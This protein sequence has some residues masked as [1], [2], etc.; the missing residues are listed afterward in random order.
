MNL[1]YVDLKSCSYVQ[2]DISINNQIICL[3]KYMNQ[4]WEKPFL[5]NVFITF[6]PMFQ[7]WHSM[8]T[9]WLEMLSFRIFQSRWLYPKIINL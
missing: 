5:N 9:H 2:E 3:L 7:Q 1:Q 8:P 6:K 4:T